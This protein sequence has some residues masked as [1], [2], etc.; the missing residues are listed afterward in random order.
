[1]DPVYGQKDTSYTEFMA[2][3][4]IISQ[5]LLRF[6]SKLLG[7]EFTDSYFFLIPRIIYFMAV[8]LTAGAFVAERKQGL[9]DRSLVAGM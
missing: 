4:L 2:P 7:L 6:I 3:G 9:L 1:M 8:S 5:V